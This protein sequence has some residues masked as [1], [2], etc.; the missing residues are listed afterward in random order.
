MSIQYPTNSSVVLSKNNHKLL[1]IQKYKLLKIQ[2]YNTIAKFSG[3]IR[4]FPLN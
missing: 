4:E 1:K 2:Q 3:T